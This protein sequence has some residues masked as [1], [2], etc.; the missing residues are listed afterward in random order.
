M[1]GRNSA[2]ERLLA[3]GLAL[4]WLAVWLQLVLPFIAPADPLNP[5][6]HLLGDTAILCT[7]DGIKIVKASDLPV[8]Q[9]GNSGKTSAASAHAC[10]LCS[11]TTIAH[12]MV[13]PTKIEFVVP[14]VLFKLRLMLAT[15]Q[16]RAP[17]PSS[18]FSARAPP[19][20]A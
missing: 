5:G 1:R 3:T 14:S 6:R 7:I 18:T 10:P 19:F 9:D 2:R 11:A 8:G 17:P 16:P 12:G 4:T 20:H 15:A 13:P